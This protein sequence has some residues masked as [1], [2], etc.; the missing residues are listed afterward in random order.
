MCESYINGVTIHG[1]ERV[2]ERSGVKS[3][4]DI[5][6]RVRRA[7]ETGKKIED[8]NNPK[9]RKYLENVL[10][11]GND[12]ETHELRVKGNEIYVF[13]HEGVLVTILTIDKKM[14]KLRSSK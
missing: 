5:E 1:R 10:R 13:S 6:S 8:F 3:L 12:W 14:E 2:K 9:F 4:K 11:A 7:W